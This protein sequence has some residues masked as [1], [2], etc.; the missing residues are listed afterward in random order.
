[1][2]RKIRVIVVEDNLS[3]QELMVDH[4]IEA[5]YHVL[6]ASS[7]DELDDHFLERPADILLLDL[8]LPG[9]NG[10]SIASRFTQAHPNLRIAMLTA[11]GADQDK[12]LGYGSGA[13]IYITKP[14][15]PSE[16]LAAVASLARRALQA[17]DPHTDLSLDLSK[18]RL[19][20]LRG[21]VSLTAAEVLILQGLAEAPNRKLEY[22][23]LLEI[24]GKEADE[25]AQNALG[26]SVHRLKLKMIES[27]AEEPAIK[28]LFKEGYQLVTLVKIY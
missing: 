7:A 17:E 9:E 15:S 13:D 20:G 23:R 26:V 28:S 8:N 16:V 1:M 11:R 19:M 21:E 12:A 2:P 10:V 4:L 18:S 3:L 14:A 25:K 27:G 5:G 24:L 22:W 6:G